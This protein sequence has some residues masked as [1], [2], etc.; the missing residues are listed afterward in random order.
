MCKKVHFLGLSCI[1]D[2]DI[3]ILSAIV[4]G[5]GVTMNPV[6]GSVRIPGV[7][8]SDVVIKVWH[9]HPSMVM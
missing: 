9:H 4:A 7:A 8:T 1:F 5:S 3:L 2:K 6:Y